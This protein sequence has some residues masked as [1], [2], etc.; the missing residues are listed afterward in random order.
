VGAAERLMRVRPRSSRSGLVV[1]S[2]G[3]LVVCVHS[4]AAGGAANRECMAVVAKTLGVTKSCVRIVRGEKGRAKQIAVDGMDAQE[5]RAR[6]E[7]AAGG[8]DRGSR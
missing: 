8:R 1:G 7:S 5:A 4:A 3:G 2:D 6:L